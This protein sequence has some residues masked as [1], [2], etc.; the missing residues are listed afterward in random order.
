MEPHRKESSHIDYDMLFKIV[1]TG[2]SNTGKSRLLERFSKGTFTEGEQITIGVEFTTKHVVLKDGTRIKLQLWDT[3]G[4]EQYR[5]ITT[6][7]YRGAHAALLV[8]DITSL[9]SFTQLKSYWIQQV[10]ECTQS[11]CILGLAATKIDIM[12]GDPELREVLRE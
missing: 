1:V 2:D 10:R 8:Y 11:S 4:A 7:Y 5:A 12:F 6:G 3:A 9:S